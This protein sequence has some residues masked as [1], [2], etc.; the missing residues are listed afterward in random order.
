M[1]STLPGRVK[2]SFLPLRSYRAHTPVREVGPGDIDWDYIFG[3][4]GSWFSTG[5][6]YT[7]LSPKTADPLGSDEESGEYGA[8][9]SFDLNYR[10]KV[11]PSKDRAREINKSIVPHGIP[12]R[13]SRRF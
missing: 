11:E 2:E 10:S 9:R 12:R 3:E 5:G 13:K 6:I 4:L 7:L 8:G 1:G